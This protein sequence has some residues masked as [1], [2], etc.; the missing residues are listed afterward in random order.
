MGI[1]LMYTNTGREGTK[2][3]EQGSFLTCPVAGPEE[4]GT[5]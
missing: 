1:L 3:T 5:N 4:V 2:K